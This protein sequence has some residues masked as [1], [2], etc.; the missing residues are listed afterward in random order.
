MNMASMI[1]PF[2]MLILWLGL[3]VYGLI[4]ATRLVVAVEEIARAMSR[5]VSDPPA[6]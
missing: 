6:R 4:L 1:V 3:I 2:L 5:R